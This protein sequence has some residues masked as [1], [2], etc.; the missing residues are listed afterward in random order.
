MPST[1]HKTLLGFTL[2]ELLIAIT[3]I[4]ILTGVVILGSGLFGIRQ[5][6]DLLLSA[7]GIVATLRTAQT[8]AAAQERGESWGVRFV[9]STSGLHHYQLF[10]G[11]SHS[12]TNVTEHSVLSGATVFAVP[13]RG[14][15]RDVIFSASSGRPTGTTSIEL[16]SGTG[17]NTITIVINSVGA[18]SRH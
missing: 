18:V 4:V 2:I 7:D 14:A 10:F 12:P 13:A 15:I 9:H 1:T 17:H 16:V 11:S 8:T 5:H 3:I 6:R